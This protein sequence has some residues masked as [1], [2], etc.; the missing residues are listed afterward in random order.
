MTT[1]DILTAAQGL[2]ANPYA[3]AA[4]ASIIIVVVLNQIYSMMLIVGTEPASLDDDDHYDMPP[5]ELAYLQSQASWSDAQ[6]QDYH[7]NLFTDNFENGQYMP[8]NDD[9]SWWGGTEPDDDPQDF[10]FEAYEAQM[11]ENQEAFY[12]ARG[13]TR[14]DF[15]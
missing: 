12:A 1:A 7:D 3:E 13:L 5:E 11:L 6:W 15:D 2:L 8:P 9:P 10:D 4:I 14:E